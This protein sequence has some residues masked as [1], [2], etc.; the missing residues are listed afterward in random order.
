MLMNPYM[1]K[2]LCYKDVGDE[3]DVLCAYFSSC[4]VHFC[5]NIKLKC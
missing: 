1:L 3:K 2:L 5:H 4:V